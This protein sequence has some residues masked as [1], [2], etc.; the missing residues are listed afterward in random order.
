MEDLPTNHSLGIPA[1]LQLMHNINFAKEQMNRH[2]Q[3]YASLLRTLT[4][5]KDSSITTGLLINDSAKQYHAI[6][7]LSRELS[8]LLR[9]PHVRPCPPEIIKSI[10]ETGG[11]IDL[12][13]NDF[14]KLEWRAHDAYHDFKRV[15]TFGQRK[16]AGS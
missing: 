11:A 4:H 15:S 7:A 8:T 9:Q 5:L 1:S 10:E 13:A 12:R 3:G 2:R 6:V 16:R 14:A